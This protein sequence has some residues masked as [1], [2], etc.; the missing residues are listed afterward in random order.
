MGKQVIV[1][2][3][4]MCEATHKDMSHLLSNHEEADTKIILHALDA[5]NDG[6]TE[7][8]IHSPDTDVLVLAIRRY[9]QMCTNTSFVTGTAAARRTIK[10]QPIVKSLGKAK[11]AA[12]PSFHAFTRADNTVCFSGKGKQTC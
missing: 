2:W 10:L 4:T 1:A 12:L 6:A 8:S 11:T 9:S 7:I 5:T 3:G